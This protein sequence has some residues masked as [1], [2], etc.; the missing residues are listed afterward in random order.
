[1]PLPQLAINALPIRTARI[2]GIFIINISPK[3]FHQC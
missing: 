3:W 2:T 1:L